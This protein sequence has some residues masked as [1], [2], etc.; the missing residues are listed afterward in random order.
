[1]KTMMRVLGLVLFSAAPAAAVSDTLGLSE[2]LTIQVIH[3]GPACSSGSVLVAGAC[4]AEGT[5]PAEPS[6]LAPPLTLASPDP[7]S[8][9]VTL[10]VG[11]DPPP[12][13]TPEPAT[14]VLVGSGL[15]L[16]AG[17]RAARR[18]TR[19]TFGGPVTELL[20]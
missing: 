11:E 19:A 3:G 4:Q 20:R 12:T 5:F 16:A 6:P 2:S 8:A 7:V 17:G 13:P 15:A 1:M 9:A 14:L 10:P 18:W